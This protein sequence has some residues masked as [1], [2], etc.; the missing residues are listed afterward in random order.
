MGNLESLG[1]AVTGGVIGRAVEPGAGEADGHTHEVQCLN[2][3][4][5]LTGAY[6]SQ[7]GQKAHVHRSLK[8][9]FHDLLHGVLHFEGKIWRTLP[10]LAWRPGELTRDYIDGKRARFISPIALFLF[11]VFL[12]FA[13]GTVTGGLDLGENPALKKDLA[14]EVAEAKVDIAKLEARRSRAAAANQPTANLDRRIRSEQEEVRAVEALQGKGV[15]HRPGQHLDRR[16]P[17][18]FATASAK[19]PKTPT[20]CSTSSRPTPINSAGP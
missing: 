14:E 16:C 7:C 8:G 2:C 11:C 13:V 12:M 10:L 18:G 20:S 9:F 1:D 3:G 4:A 15:R 17:A 6:C 19:P 5:E